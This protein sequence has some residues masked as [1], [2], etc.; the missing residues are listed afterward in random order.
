M[1]G[2]SSGNWFGGNAGSFDFAAMEFNLAAGPNQSKE[3]WLWQV[4][5]GISSPFFMHRFM[6]IEG[7]CIRGYVEYRSERNELYLL[8]QST[9]LRKWNAYLFGGSWAPTLFCLAAS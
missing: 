7:G 6:Y 8:S 3:I 5:G 2:G 9:G 1:G 4:S